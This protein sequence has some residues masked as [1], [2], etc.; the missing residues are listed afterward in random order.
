MKNLDNL[1]SQDTTLPS[2]ALPLLP[3]PFPLHCLPLYLSTICFHFGVIDD[4]ETLLRAS[5]LT[6]LERECQEHH[7]PSR[8]PIS[9]SLGFT[10][11]SKSSSPP[12]SLSFPIIASFK[13]TIYFVLPSSNI[14]CIPLNLFSAN[15]VPSSA[16]DRWMCRNSVPGGRRVLPASVFPLVFLGSCSTYIYRWVWRKA[17]RWLAIL[18]MRHIS[19]IWCHYSLTSGRGGTASVCVCLCVL[20]RACTV[21]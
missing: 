5:L 6:S 10:R 2:S 9:P 7:T 13:V 4:Q 18:H 8:Y 3:P 21:E 11:L 16:C 14:A 15:H 12:L 17:R 1:P 19:T 20:V